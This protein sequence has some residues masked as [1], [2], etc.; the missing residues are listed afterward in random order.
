MSNCPFCRGHVG[1]APRCS[2]CGAYRSRQIPIGWMYRMGWVREREFNTETTD[3]VLKAN[4]ITYKDLLAT[5]GIDSPEAEAF[6][7]EKSRNDT[8]FRRL[9]PLVR[10]EAL[11]D[12]VNSA[13]EYTSDYESYRWLLFFIVAFVC[14]V[15]GGVCSIFPH[16][17]PL[18][19]ACSCLTAVAV[20]WLVG[21]LLRPRRVR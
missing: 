9:A 3:G 10:M 15:A 18:C 4:L 19:V 21:R 7:D 16:P 2:Q 5:H 17:F 11:M 14:L 20:T 1:T 13:K 8:E 6:K 12:V